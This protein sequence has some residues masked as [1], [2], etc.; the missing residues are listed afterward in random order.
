MFTT[1]INYFYKTNKNNKKYGWKKDK[2][3]DRDSIVTF[4]K[5]NHKF[6]HI[7]SVD[8]REFCPD[9]YTQ[10]NLGSCTANAIA[11]AYEY[12]MIKQ[13]EENIFVPSR[14]FI[15]YNERKMINTINEDSGAEIR[16]GIKTI[17]IDGICNETDWPYDI[18]KFTDTP[19]EELY[20]TAKYH[21]AI[22]YKKLTQNI[23]HFKE[24]LSRGY[25]FVFGFMVY[26]SFENQSVQETG[27]MPMPTDSENLLGGHAVMAVGFNE[28]DKTILVRNSWGVDWGMNGYFT[29]P[30]EFILN[31]KYCSD[32]WVISRVKDV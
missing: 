7:N 10:G 4:N 19:P 8:L 6:F 11:A 15:Y 5:L 3:D 12:D 16:D 18:T 9:I 1:L 2:T 20:Q 14:L 24:C 13:K 29:M 31:P 27:I 28:T 32:F 17:N 25:P 23:D 30:Y 22:K 21:T 26:E